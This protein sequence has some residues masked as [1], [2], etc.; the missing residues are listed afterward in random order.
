METSVT[1]VLT[2]TPELALMAADIRKAESKEEKLK[3]LKELFS[4]WWWEDIEDVEV[5]APNP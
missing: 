2:G 3:L 1:L 5:E 4:D